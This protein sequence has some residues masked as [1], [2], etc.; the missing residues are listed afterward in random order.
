MDGDPGISPIDSLFDEMANEVP[1]AMVK[2]SF[3]EIKWVIDS[4]NKNEPVG[5]NESNLT[6]FS[7]YF[8]EFLRE[9]NSWALL[10]WMQETYIYLAGDPRDVP[11]KYIRWY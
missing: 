1:Q 11:E 2:E 10:K 8:M 9:G 4:K 3:Q 7:G 6:F 5:W